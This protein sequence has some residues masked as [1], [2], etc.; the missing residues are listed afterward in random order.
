MMGRYMPTDKEKK[1]DEKSRF[2]FCPLCGRKGLY[3]IRQQYYRC[4]YCGTYLISPTGK[5]EI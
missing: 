2:Q 1:T 4:R 5:K 3:H